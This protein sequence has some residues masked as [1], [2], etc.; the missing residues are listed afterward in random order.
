MVTPSPATARA[1]KITTPIPSNLSGKPTR[2]VV[3][4]SKMIAVGTAEVTGKKLLA[5]DFRRYPTTGEASYTL[6]AG[7][8]FI[9][10]GSERDAVMAAQQM[11]NKSAHKKPNYPFAISVS[12][13]QDGSYL[14]GKVSY[15]AFGGKSKA[16]V[17]PFDLERDSGNWH[18]QSVDLKPS[19][20]GIVGEDG[21]VRNTK[22]THT[23]T[24]PRPGENLIWEE[25]SGIQE[26]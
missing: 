11:I 22:Y 9:A 1:P 10:Y 21:W 7:P 17:Y 24:L 20:V 23:L 18:L 3:P 16:I 5:D 13:A 2:I 6:A 19:V 14:L 12:A 8:V 4:D 15:E 26:Y 25:K